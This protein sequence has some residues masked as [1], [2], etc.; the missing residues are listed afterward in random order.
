MTAKDVVRNQPICLSRLRPARIREN[1]NP[2]SPPKETPNVERI[3]IIPRNVGI[4]RNANGALDTMLN[5]MKIGVPI[6]RKKAEL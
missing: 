1:S 5:P 4:E 3:S 6:T 2:R